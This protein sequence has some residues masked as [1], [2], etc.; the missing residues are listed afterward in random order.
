MGS[1][2]LLLNSSTMALKNLVG[3]RIMNDVIRATI[4]AH[5]KGG[6]GKIEWRVL[7]VDSLS[8][9][10]VSACT[11]MHE[12]SAEGIT[13]VETIEKR[14]EPM[15]AME[16]IYLIGSSDASVRCL[17][18]DFSSQNRTTYKFAHVYFTEAC[19]DE[20][21]KEICNSLAAK[22]IKT[23]KEIN[24]AFTPHES[25]VY[26]L[27]SPDNFQLYYN[28][29]R[30]S[31]RSAAMEKM[32]EQIATLCS[33]LGEY[34]SIRYRA[35]YD[36]NL[37]LAQLVQQKLG[38]Y[39][40][41]D[42]TMGEGAEKAKSQLIILDR[43]FDIT[44]ALLHELTFQAMA[45]DLLDINNDVYKYEAGEG[46]MKEVILDENDDV[47]T[48]LRH[49]HIAVVSQ[50]VTKKLK[51]FNAEKKIQ[52]SG[53]KN[54][55]RALSQMI[56]KMPQHQKEMTKFSTHLQL[57]EE[58]MKNYQGYIDKLCKVEQDLAMGTDAEGE[59]VKD[60]MKNIV[61]ILLDPNVTI[62]DK[63]RVILLY[64]LSKSGISEEN[65]IKLIQHA[66]IP[67]EKH[68]MIRN[69]SNLGVNVVADPGLFENNRRKIWTMRRKERTSEN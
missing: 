57:A 45:L 47:W 21:F 40:A 24:I 22:R 48:E 54:D 44:S 23:L 42:P 33:T 56:K 11:K 50:N 67:P 3:Q 29:L 15:P 28:P 61:P 60:H 36:K 64:I 52:S 7:V 9:K 38:A 58:C 1:P 30:A 16:A 18:Q 63:I 31:E 46:N 20:R 51:K 25:Q 12:L 55:M 49:Q 4:K 2:C 37:E 27:D 19:P 17:L 13:I 41:D 59:K 26:S 43:G 39:K 34:P 62:N 68:C 53:D 69:V 10:T 65:L 6:P 8:M 32:A 66:Q 14:R 5:N 35:D